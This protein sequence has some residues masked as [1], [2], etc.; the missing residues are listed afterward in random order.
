METLRSIK[1]LNSARVGFLASPAGEHAE[2]L[3]LLQVLHHGSRPV[4]TMHLD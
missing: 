2:R 1:V 3:I 4:R